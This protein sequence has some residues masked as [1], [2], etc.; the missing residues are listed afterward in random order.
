MEKD[1]DRWNDQKKKTHFKTARLYYHT[2]EIWW[3]ELGINIGSEQDGSGSEFRRP[4]IIL[5][6]FGQ[7]TCLVIPLTTSTKEHPLRPAIGI[8][9]GKQAH[10]LLSQIRVIDIRRLVSKIGYLDKHAFEN[11]RK[12]VKDML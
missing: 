1:F 6:S 11:I 3:C 9:D 8:V 10:A 12:S 2:R 7:R 5:A 4:V